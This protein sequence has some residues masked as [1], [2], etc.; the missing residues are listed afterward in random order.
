MKILVWNPLWPNNGDLLFFK[1]CFVKHLNLQAKILAK[2]GCEVD[3]VIPTWFDSGDIKKHAGVNYIDF[4]LDYANNLIGGYSNVMEELYAYS[5]GVL[6]KR[7]GLELSRKLA[8]EYDTILL[9]EN[10]VPFL[11]ELY[12]NALIVHQMPGFFSRPPYPHTVCFEPEGLYKDSIIYK[13][14]DSFLSLGS[15]S[16]FDID[17]FKERVRYNINLINPVSYRDIENETFSENNVLLP[18]QT[19]KHYSFSVDSPYSNQLELLFSVLSNMSNE[20]NLVVTQYV[21]SLTSDKVLNLD[22]FHSIK[23]DFPCLTYSENFDEIANVS[24]YMLQYVQHVYTFSSSVAV[25]AL[26]WDKKFTVIGESFLSQLERSIKD[27][28]KNGDLFLKGVLSKY[29]PLANKVTEDGAFLKA[30]LIE[31]LERKR[32]GIAGAKLLVNFES[33]D[34]NYFANIIGK[35]RPEASM[36]GLSKKAPIFESYLK[37]ISKVKRVIESKDVEVISFDVFDTLVE[38]SVETPADV[39]N[40]LE[41]QL[42]QEYGAVFDGFSKVRLN[43]ELEARNNKPE[44]EITIDSIYEYIKKFYNLNDSVVSEILLIE[45]EVEYRVIRSRKFGKAIWNLAKNANKKIV[46]V[47]DM[48]HTTSTIEQILHNAGYHD[49]DKLFVSSEYDCRKK[50]GK[51]YDFVKSYL[52]DGVIVRKPQSILHIGDN[53]LADFEQAKN[54]G[55]SAYRIPRSIE[56]MRLNPSYKNIFPPRIGAG[57]RA[58][59]MIAGA[60]SSKMFDTSS[61]SMETTSLFMGSKDRL[62]YSALGP[63]VYGFVKWLVY[64][65]KKDGISKLYFLSRE[66]W[67]LY[68]A[69][70]LVTADDEGAVPGVYLY[71]SRRSTRVAA[72]KNVEDIHGV[73]SQPYTSGI[74]LDKL[75]ESRFGLD[76][77]ALDSNCLEGTKFSSYKCYLDAEHQTKADFM[78]LCIKLKDPILKIARKER[79]PYLNYLS[80][81]GLSFE[82]KPAVVDIGWK[83]N[84]QGALGA[85]M[86]RELDGYYYALLQGS[87]KWI[88]LG[89]NISAYGGVGISQT[90][91]DP[92]VNN[93][94]LVE[95]LMCSSDKSFVSM[96]Q[97]GARF[98]PTYKSEDRYFERMTFIDI[99]HAGALEFVSDVVSVFGGLQSHLIP[100]SSLSTACLRQFLIKPNV[101]DVNLISQLMFEDAFGGVG[102]KSL[103]SSRDR[104]GSVWKAGFDALKNGR[105]NVKKD[106]PSQSKN[107]S[108]IKP[109]LALDKEYHRSDDNKFESLGRSLRRFISAPVLA[110]EL[111]IIKITSTPRKYQKYRRSNEL[112]FEDS[113]SK[114]ALGWYNI[115]TKYIVGTPD[116]GNVTSSGGSLVSYV[117]SIEKRIIKAFATQRAFNK[118]LRSK[119]EYFKDSKNVI[120]KKWYSIRIR[121]V[122]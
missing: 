37:E 58:R 34:S 74:R 55:L 53:K 66:G 43:A 61:G 25:Q 26:A 46:V 78:L 65:A 16:T 100:D 54:H 38:R 118:Y 10:P 90:N 108:E 35:F 23:K 27:E 106:I 57:E 86:H 99:V 67:I 96:R 40:F 77:E 62:G 32:A 102:S 56:R 82:R 33:L 68:K 19:S 80:S 7:I 69:Y 20:S 97:E 119:D 21:N 42:V 30:L 89:H 72:L 114:I 76:L 51:L 107:I 120:A 116:L 73:S 50:E 79:L 105:I 49:Y 95:F 110:I 11:K 98:Y 88:G 47:S 31:M 2:E 121:V 104:D 52:I 13:D 70:C 24:Q 113:K 60:I 93:R 14:L 63:F 48:Y 22:L 6:S 84:M 75:L 41:A 109:A 44:G 81:M 71:A 115:R 1:N 36:R 17:V 92:L 59:S 91:T 8:L 45:L 94:H 111:L 87:E 101:D 117:D 122:D 3:C 39:Y 18:L 85:L 9:W 12:P 29:Q 28:D 103:V 4:S 5:D 112:F 83:A 64:Q 15:K